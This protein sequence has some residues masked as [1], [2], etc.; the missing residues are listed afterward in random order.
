MPAAF[1]LVDSKSSTTGVLI[2]TFRGAGEPQTGSF[3]SKEPSE[4]E[5]A[6]REAMRAGGEKG[7]ARRRPRYADVAS[8]EKAASGLGCLGS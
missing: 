4:A 2:G 3:A 1:E 5:I 8:L 7:G 6:R